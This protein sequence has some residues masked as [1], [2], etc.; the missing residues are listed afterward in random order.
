MPI[1]EYVCLACEKKFEVIRP[2]SQADAPLACQNC[3][4]EQVKRKQ[5][6][7]YAMSGG[8]SVSG[9]SGGCHCDSACS[10]GNCAGCTR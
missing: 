2:I 5:A 9:T 4:V 1:Y 7:F 3:G 6:V 8:H 10:G